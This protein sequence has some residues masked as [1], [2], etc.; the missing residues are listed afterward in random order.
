MRG[1][2]TFCLNVRGM[3]TNYNLLRANVLQKNIDVICLSET[4][5]N[6]NDLTTSYQLP[7]YKSIRLDREVYRDNGERM[8]GG[9]LVMY[10]KDNIG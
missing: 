3:K 10:I 4:K 2:S 1:F 6:P 9:G 5:F 8:G 7:S